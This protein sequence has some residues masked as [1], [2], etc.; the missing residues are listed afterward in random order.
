M[1]DE[2][3]APSFQYSRPPQRRRRGMTERQVKVANPDGTT[4]THTFWTDADL[5][6]QR[7]WLED[8]LDA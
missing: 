2:Q 7:A 3:L 8:D 4:T 6:A 5:A 1:A